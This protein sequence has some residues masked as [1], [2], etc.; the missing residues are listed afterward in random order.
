MIGK[1]VISISDRS[2]VEYDL[3]IST[4]LA[5]QILYI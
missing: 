3:S 2:E 5:K 1:Y 4:G